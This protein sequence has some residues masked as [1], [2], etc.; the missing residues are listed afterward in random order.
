MLILWVQWADGI[1]NFDN[2]LPTFI[3]KKDWKYL[4]FFQKNQVVSSVHDHMEM[5]EGK[6]AA[7]AD[8]YKDNLVI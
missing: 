4:I 8:G 5:G 7:G 6:V 3:K 2:K 1:L